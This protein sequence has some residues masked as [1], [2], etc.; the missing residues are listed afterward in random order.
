[1]TTLSW[2]F[3]SI[4]KLV[5]LMQVLLTKELLRIIQWGAATSVERALQY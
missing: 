1:M 3:P 2:G 5:H 4:P